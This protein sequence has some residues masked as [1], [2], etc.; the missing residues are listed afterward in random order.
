[1]RKAR[2]RT[3][4]GERRDRSRPGA[5]RR[6]VYAAFRAAAREGGSGGSDRNARDVELEMADRRAG[7][8]ARGASRRRAV[9]ARLG[10]TGPLHS[11]RFGQI[12][13]RASVVNLQLASQPPKP[14]A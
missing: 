12:L 10:G 9:T 8:A 6:L 4:V 2:S 1:P 7:P 13:A 5:G 3:E 11:G 14:G